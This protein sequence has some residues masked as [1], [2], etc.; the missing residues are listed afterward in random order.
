[1]EN[2]YISFEWD[3]SDMVDVYMDLGSDIEPIQEFLWL[4]LGEL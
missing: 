1:M 2:C 3:Y 4:P